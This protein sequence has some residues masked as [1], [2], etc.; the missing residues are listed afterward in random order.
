[1]CHTIFHQINRII[2][3][4]NKDRDKQDRDKFPKKMSQ[5]T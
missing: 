1:M 2:K 3:C 5:F 4:L